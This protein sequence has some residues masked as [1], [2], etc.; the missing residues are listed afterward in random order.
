[1]LRMLVPARRRE[2]RYLLALALRTLMPH[3]QLQL[4]LLYL[5]G[6]KL[7]L[8][9]S[10]RVRGT[11]YPA[12][13]KLVSLLATAFLIMGAREALVSLGKLCRKIVA[14]MKDVSAA[15]M[16]CHI[17]RLVAAAMARRAVIHVNALLSVAHLSIK[18]AETAHGM[19]QVATRLD[20]KIGIG[21]CHAKLARLRT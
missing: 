3:A 2:Q 5:L 18:T 20:I 17:M 14:A 4:K 16:I 12:V 21:S 10:L 6:L 9:S 15:R 1:M 8:F 13:Q 19:D 7:R 11:I